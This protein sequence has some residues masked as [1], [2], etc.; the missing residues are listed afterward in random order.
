MVQPPDVELLERWRRGDRAAG[1]KLID[2][3]FTAV[4]RFFR[5]KVP[6]DFEDLVQRTFLSC[7][8]SKDRIREGASFR[9]YA[10]GT[11]RLVLLKHFK[12]LARARDIV[13]WD[14]VTVQE[15]HAPS[16]STFV[17][18]RRDDRVLLEALRALPLKYQIALEL[19][20]WEDLRVSELADALDV[21]ES[22]IQSRLTRGR[23]KLAAV[24]R[25]LGRSPVPLDST[26]SR[27]DDWARSVREQQLP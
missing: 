22:T 1:G 17:A 7:M 10:L 20:F 12:A 24:L 4:C 21:P 16:P 8:E 27:L 23:E 5:N 13:D 26:L 14:E 19:H 15:L 25:R 11:A 9:A 2:R 3:H 18:A 6:G